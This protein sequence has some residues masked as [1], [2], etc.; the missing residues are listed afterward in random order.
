MKCACQNITFIE[1][2][3]LIDSFGNLRAQCAAIKEVLV[4][5]SIWSDFK[6]AANRD[7]DEA[8]HHYILLGAFENGHIG[9]IT[10][11][12]HRHILPEGTVSDKLI[13]QY[14]K[15][16]VEKWMLE[17]GYL[18]RH[19]KSRIFQGKLS[20]LLCTTFIEDQGWIIDNLEALG[21]VNDIEATSPD[22]KSCSIEVK[23][24]GQDDLRFQEVVEN[25][26]SNNASTNSYNIYDGY[27]YFLSRIFE[28]AN[29]FSD[30]D[31]ERIVIII[32]SNMAWPFLR[33][34]IKDDWIRNRPISFSDS[35]SAVWDIHMIK[36][37]QK[38]ANINS[39]LDNLIGQLKE[40][41][42]VQEQ[43]CLEYSIGHVVEF[44]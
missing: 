21:G 9:K 5:D 34:A 26:T 4:P 25:L 1:N 12:I 41:W 13:K 11:P 22:E 3:N 6:T 38:Y 17:D 18:E 40:L 35:S 20:E 31:K 8:R 10:S 42:I 39:E 29:Q 37:K 43:N 23:Y 28:A 15:D 24:I 32:V 27:N 16:L 19:R 36:L 14:K 7:L 2:E 33:Q 44:N 30:S